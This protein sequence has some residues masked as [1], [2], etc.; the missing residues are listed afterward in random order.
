MWSKSAKKLKKFLDEK[1]KNLFEWLQN[2][3]H[4]TP[5]ILWW[6]IWFWI[7]AV[8]LL[9][10]SSLIL[11]LYSRKATLAYVSFSHSQ[12]LIC[13]RFNSSTPLQTA[14][15]DFLLKN[16]SS[17]SPDPISSMKTK[18]SPD[19]TSNGCDVDVNSLPPSSSLTTTSSTSR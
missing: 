14:K 8:S 16:G 19:S 13:F 9:F 18:T 4:S 10:P 6:K 5:I 11:A 17:P 1:K 12:P 2:L 15:R 7:L 3:K